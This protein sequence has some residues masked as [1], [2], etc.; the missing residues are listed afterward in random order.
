MKDCLRFLP[1]F[2]KMS[3]PDNAI[4]RFHISRQNSRD[5]S[6]HCHHSNRHNVNKMFCRH[7]LSESS[8]VA[9]AVTTIAPTPPV[10]SAATAAKASAFAAAAAMPLYLRPCLVDNDGPSHQICS[11]HLVYCRLCFCSRGHR[12]KSKAS[13]FATE[14]ISD[15]ADRFDLSQSFKCLL[16]LVFS[17]LHCQIS[18]IDIHLK[19]LFQN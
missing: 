9:A 18:H 16:Q 2:L 4:V 5:A 10:S 1:G 14:S 13:R 6:A 19:F 3:S 17:R 8:P 7:R 15:D 12:H 11:V